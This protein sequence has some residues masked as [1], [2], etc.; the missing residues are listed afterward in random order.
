ML[1]TVLQDFS[2][3]LRSFRK[4]PGFTAVVIVSIALGD[5]AAPRPRLRRGEKSGTEGGDHQ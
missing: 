5:S 2:Y 4:S 1:E 3:A